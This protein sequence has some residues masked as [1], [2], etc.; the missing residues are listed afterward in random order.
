M[1]YSIVFPKTATVALSTLVPQG[2][3]VEDAT[4]K[5]TSILKTDLG[6]IKFVPS[7]SKEGSKPKRLKFV[8][9]KEKDDEGNPLR[10]AKYTSSLEGDASVAPQ[11]SQDLY[12]FLW[13]LYEFEDVTGIHADNGHSLQFPRHIAEYVRKCLAPMT[14]RKEVTETKEAVP[15]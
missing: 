8:K 15:A 9:S 7:K 11:R 10:L 14:P 13:D 6:R 12:D 2:V 1:S 5:L 3:S 4:D